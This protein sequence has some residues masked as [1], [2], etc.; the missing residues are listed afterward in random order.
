MWHFISLHALFAKTKQF[1]EK[2]YIFYLENISCD[3]FIESNQK[4][5]SISA[6]K[7]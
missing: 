3:P 2:K 4:E 7:G 1:S 5:E 6:Y